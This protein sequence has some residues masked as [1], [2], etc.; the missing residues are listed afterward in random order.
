MLMQTG[1]LRAHVPFYSSYNLSFFPE[2]SQIGFD[3]ND[4]AITALISIKYL[5]YLIRQRCAM[6]VCRDECNSSLK[7]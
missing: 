4:A 7:S 3:D 1:D 2:A 5:P 6:G